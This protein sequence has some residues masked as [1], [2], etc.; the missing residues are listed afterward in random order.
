M[1]IYHYTK[2][3]HLYSI[4]TDGFIATEKK[5][6][7]SNTANVTDFVW[8]TESIFFPKT[9]LP[10]VSKFAYTNLPNHVAI[11]NLYVDWEELSAYI[12]NAYRFSFDSNDKRFKKW[13][14]SEERKKM[15]SNSHWTYME[16]IANKVSDNTRLFWISNNDIKLDSF[17]LEV[18]KNKQWVTLLENVNLFDA[19]SK[20][21][22]TIS[23]LKDISVATCNSLDMPLQAM[24]I[25][26]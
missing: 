24:K 11:K 18:Y 26:A 22:K 4:F 6:G 25:A 13:F 1:K 20:T 15:L 16:N 10:Y 7:H 14:F 3:Y 23:D 2:Q 8:L 19:D 5:R 21:L 17:S 9:A 12:G